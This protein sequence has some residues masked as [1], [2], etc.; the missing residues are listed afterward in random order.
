M[1]I[2]HGGSIVRLA[3]WP[4]WRVGLIGRAIIGT[5][6]FLFTAREVQA[7]GF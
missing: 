4:E 1:M 3:S 2:R 6:F 7:D 5:R